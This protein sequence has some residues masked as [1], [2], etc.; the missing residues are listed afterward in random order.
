MKEVTDGSDSSDF[1]A[2]GD[3]PPPVGGDLAAR[4]CSRADAAR[5]G[6]PDPG[7][8]APPALARRRSP[9][10]GGSAAL[11][12]AATRRLSRQ[13]GVPRDRRNPARRFARETAS[14]HYERAW[15]AW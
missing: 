9:P 13:A 5:G 12:R 2:G 4:T 15:R 1:R 6:I 7:G 8:A 10:P 14:R 3:A 11:Q